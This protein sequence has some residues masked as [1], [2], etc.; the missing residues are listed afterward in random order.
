MSE[1]S[2][3]REIQKTP[4]PSIASVALVDDFARTLFKINNQI[5][6]MRHLTAQL[7]SSRDSHDLRA[8]LYVLVEWPS[9]SQ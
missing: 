2:I 6:E 1:T 3:A 4:R 9:P 5:A 8:E 7:G